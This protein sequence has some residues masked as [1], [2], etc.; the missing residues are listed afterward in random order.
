MLSGTGLARV[1][2]PGITPSS[3]HPDAATR[4]ALNVYFQ[5]WTARADA[6]G[7]TDFAALQVAF[8]DSMVTAG[9]AVA[10]EYRVVLDFGAGATDGRG[11]YLNPGV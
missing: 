5:G 3:K 8:A 2:G 11:G 6:E 10:L 9:E 1:L 4:K 7:R